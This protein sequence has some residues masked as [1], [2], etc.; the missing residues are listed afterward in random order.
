MSIGSNTQPSLARKIFRGM[1]IFLGLG[2]LVAATAAWGDKRNLTHLEHIC[3]PTGL[4]VDQYVT[5]PQ[6][7]D[8][9]AELGRF[10]DEPIYAASFTIRELPEAELEVLNS[11]REGQPPVF[12]RT[13]KSE[14]EFFLKVGPQRYLRVHQGADAKPFASGMVGCVARH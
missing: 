10:G 2:T 12:R 4:G 3:Y 8:F 11:G 7:L 5:L 9:Q 1:T 14:T 6:P 13:M